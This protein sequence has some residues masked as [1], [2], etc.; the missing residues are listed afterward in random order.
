MLSIR[1]IPSRASPITDSP[2]RDRRHGQHAA[3]S[4][5]RLEQMRPWAASIPRPATSSAATGQQGVLIEP[6]ASGNQVLGNQIGVIGPIDGFYYQ[7][8]N[9]AEGVLIES[10]GTASDPASIVYTSSNMIGGA[11]SRVRQCDLGQ[12]ELWRAHRRRGGDPKP[13]R[14]QLYRGSARRRLSSSAAAIP[15][16]DADGVRI[17]DAPDNQIGGAVAS[18]GNVI[19]SNSRQ[20]CQHHRRRRDR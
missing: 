3:R 19:S 17:D 7:I 9:G 1:S 13:G 6:G 16:I 12:P 8:G 4:R 20:R 14:G 18:D 10:S 5:A 2:G 15:A 11:V